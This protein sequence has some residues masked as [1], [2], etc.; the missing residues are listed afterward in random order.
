MSNKRADSAPRREIKMYDPNQVVIIGID[1]K[2]GVTHWGY[3]E[4]SNKTPL[5]EADVLFT[6]ANG[7]LQN[8]LARRDGDKV[9]VVAGRGRT[10]MLREANKR[11]IAEG[12]PPWHL[13]VQIVM[14]DAKK[15]LVL[16]HGENSHRRE[17]SPMARARQAYELAQQFPEEEAATIMGLGVVQFRNL[18]K[19]LNASPEV[20]RAVA[21][22][23]L[24]QTAAIELTVLPEVEQTAR[25]AEV[26]ASSGGGKPTQRDV[27]AKINEATGKAPPETPSARVKK[28]IAILEKLEEDATKDDLWSVIRKIRAAV[29]PSGG[30]GA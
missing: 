26:L 13:P 28:V 3:D 19:L 22:G 8:V 1:T 21:Q 25:L 30:R 23:A 16:K 10:R 12:L 14:G 15:M 11:R 18:Q 7:V 24:G 5:V 9:V 20:A 2:D 4:D 29:K 27:R 6:F 17:Q